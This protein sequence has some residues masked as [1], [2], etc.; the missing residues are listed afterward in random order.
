MEIQWNFNRKEYEDCYVIT[1]VLYSLIPNA[2]VTLN[3]VTIT[4]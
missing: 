2:L 1:L 3:A 4:G